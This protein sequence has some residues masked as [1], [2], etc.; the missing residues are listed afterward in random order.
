MVRQSSGIRNPLLP[1]GRS[2]SYQQLVRHFQLSHQQLIRDFQESHQ[3]RT[4]QADIVPARRSIRVRA[5]R[6]RTA[7]EAA[8]EEEMALQVTRYS[9]VAIKEGHKDTFLYETA[10][11]LKRKEM[12]E[13][14]APLFGPVARMFDLS[15]SRLHPRTMDSLKALPQRIALSVRRY[16]QQEQQNV[17]RAKCARQQLHESQRAV[18]FPLSRQVDQKQKPAPAQNYVD[19]KPLP[20]KTCETIQLKSLLFNLE[21]GRTSSGEVQ[22]LPQSVMLKHSL[23]EPATADIHKRIFK[24]LGLPCDPHPNQAHHIVETMESLTLDQETPLT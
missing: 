5:V 12:I 22:S 1:N 2:Q 13:S 3:Q 18:G 23:I 7:R 11:I 6:K 19:A 15:T 10:P 9:A 14:T 24:T 4:D 21:S 16:E 20:S 8:H 17:T